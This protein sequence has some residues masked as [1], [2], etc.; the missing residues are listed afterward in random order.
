MDSDKGEEN[1]MGGN[2]EAR[3]GCG[4]GEG[5]PGEMLA[6]LIWDLALRKDPSWED[7]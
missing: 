2:T 5:I 1:H 7:G 3:S 4:G 6:L